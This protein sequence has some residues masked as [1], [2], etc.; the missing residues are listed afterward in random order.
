M[1]KKA[2]WGA[3][4]LAF[5]LSAGPVQASTI[6]TF[7]WDADDVFG[8]MFVINNESGF[9]FPT[10]S[11]LVRCDTE[12]PDESDGN[13]NIPVPTIG[14]LGSFRTFD[15][16]FSSSTILSA[17]L[18]F[19]TPFSISLFLTDDL[20]IETLLRDNTLTSPGSARIDFEA[21]AQVA[22]PEPGSLLLLGSGLGAAW[23]KR[24]RHR[25]K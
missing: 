8:P 15:I 3:A 10:V 12:C 7:S 1:K 23:M 19:A 16:D 24:R 6:G 18:T 2:I 9:D 4:L 14:S 20:G 25:Q 5:F 13:K 22:V 11:L 17:K 21:P